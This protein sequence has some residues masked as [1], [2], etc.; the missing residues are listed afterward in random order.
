MR[1]FKWKKSL[2]LVTSVAVLTSVLVSVFTYTPSQELTPWANVGGCGAGGSGGAAGDGIRWIGQGVD[3]GEANI[4]VISRYSLGQNFAIHSWTPRL[5]WRPTWSTEI[6]ITQ[7]IMSARAEVQYRTNQTAS[8][9]TTG[10]L[11]DLSLDFTKNFGSNAEFALL[12]SWTLPT[13]QYDIA[14]GPDAAREFLPGNL[15]KGGGLNV[16]S[17]GLSYTT[18]VEDGLWIWDMNYSHPVAM[19]LTGENEFLDSHYSSYANRAGPR[20]KYYFKNYGENDL[21]A[22]TPPSISSSI[23]YGYRGE[24]GLVHS[25]G[26][27][28]SAPLGV[29]WIQGEKENLY[30]PRPDPD[31]QAWNVALSY[32]LEF[33][34][35]N[36][37]F[38]VGISMP[39]H[40]LAND[41]GENEYDETPMQSWDRPDWN[42]LGQQWTIAVGVKTSLL[43]GSSDED[44]FEDY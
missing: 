22:Y 21:G 4:E 39:I 9:R 16:P 26:A 3:G 18:D 33:S 11:G 23:Y 20:F 1:W 14:R 5:T 10:G 6:G 7:P 31:H 42:D 25:F 13:A 36:Y 17:L 40:D 19:S 15:Q 30:D 24:Q 44:E 34:D 32:G 12:A 29:A 2:G 8:D 38:F 37:P 41:P 43:A 27:N 35:Q 28:L